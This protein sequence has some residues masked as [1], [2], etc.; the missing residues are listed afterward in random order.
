MSGFYG[1]RLGLLARS[2]EHP[3]LVK[4][5]LPNRSLNNRVLSVLEDKSLQRW[6]TKQ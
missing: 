2:S 3:N 6:V 1:V 5:V 4:F